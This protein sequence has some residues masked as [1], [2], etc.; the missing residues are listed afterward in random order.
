VVS[1]IAAGTG[2]GFLLCMHGD[3]VCSLIRISPDDHALILIHHRAQMAFNTRSID[4]TNLLANV[5][6]LA[7]AAKGFNAPALR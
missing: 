1:V 2:I 5:G 4:I 3:L 6:I 7:H